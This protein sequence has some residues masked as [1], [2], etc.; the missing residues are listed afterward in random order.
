MSY[1]AG[2]NLELYRVSVAVSTLDLVLSHRAILLYIEREREEEREGE[3]EGERQGGR[4]RKRERER[5][6]ER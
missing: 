5:E 6:R 4:E 2:S 3:R 1:G